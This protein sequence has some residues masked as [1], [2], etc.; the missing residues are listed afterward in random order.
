MINDLGLP[1]II[2]FGRIFRKKPMKL[3]KTLST[4]YP[5]FREDLTN[6]VNY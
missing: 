6:P 5:D 2:Y 1:S 4:P 3:P